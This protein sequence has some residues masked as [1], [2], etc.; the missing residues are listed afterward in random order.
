M[1][2]RVVEGGQA[3]EAISD[4]VGVSPRTV[5]QWVAR[6]RI[7]RS[8]PIASC[9]NK[10][11]HNIGGLAMGNDRRT[12]VVNHYLQFWNAP[13][14]FIRGACVFPFNGGHDPARTVGAL[15]Y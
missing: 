8:P 13:N 4:V 9:P 15:T 1:V 5:R 2:R 12:S 6:F 14:L 10:T 11:T 3:P 7:A